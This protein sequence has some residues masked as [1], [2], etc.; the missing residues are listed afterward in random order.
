MCLGDTISRVADEGERTRN[1]LSSA[2]SKRSR[3]SDVESVR[4]E[5]FQTRYRESKIKQV[6]NVPITSF[7]RLLVDSDLDTVT[8]RMVHQK[9][10]PDPTF[11]QGTYAKHLIFDVCNVSSASIACLK[12]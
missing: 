9:L 4:T 1:K 12:Y 5:E 3:T 11:A 10:L 7:D 8:S 6:A 2:K